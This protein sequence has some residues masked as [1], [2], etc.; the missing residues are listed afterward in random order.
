MNHPKFKHQSQMA[1]K[2]ATVYVVD[3]G[4]STAQKHENGE[5]K[6]NFALT[7]VWDKVTSIMALD[8]KTTLQGVVAVRTDETDNELGN[9]PDYH[10]ISVLQHLKALSLS[11]LRDLQTQ[12]VSSNTDAGD[13]IS[14]LV[15]AIHMIEKTCKKLKYIRRIVMVTSGR[16][17]WSEANLD[18]ISR[19]LKDEGIELL[20]LGVDFGPESDDVMK[21][22]R[23]KEVL[24]NEALIRRLVPEDEDARPFKGV[25]ASIAEAI[26]ELGIPRL[27]S[28]R[29]V[30]SF[31]GQLL[32]G[33][34]SNYDDALCIDVER[35]PRTMLRKAP[36]A[37]AFAAKD[38]SQ[39]DDAE[40][41]SSAT[42]KDE[43]DGG[44][45]AVVR[46]QR[47]YQVIDASLPDGKKEIPFEE[48]AKGYE[49][50]R[51][52]VHVSESDMPILKMDTISGLEIV[53][54]I[55]AENVF[56]LSTFIL[57]S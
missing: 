4:K 57:P 14:A 7:Y 32:L 18:E 54:F 45:L 27:K 50:G 29:P 20:V 43:G 44:D 19:K 25:F 13:A 11:E 2:E 51:T 34:P 21:T 42:V 12:I 8:R 15:I 9:D 55:P 3:V 26:E 35:Y 52:A 16:G 10:H 37:S 1:E 33:D 47:M 38:A 39:G 17:S 23:S 22:E 48:L 46:N 49:Y 36:T 24:Q 31:K 41:Q 30:P 28:V 5:T 6:L 53:G 40:A 56:S